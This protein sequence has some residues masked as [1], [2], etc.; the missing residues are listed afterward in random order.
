M[1]AGKQPA[2]KVNY[3][4]TAKRFK[5]EDKKNKKDKEK[6]E[7]GPGTYDILS[8]WAGKPLFGK[9][10]GEES[11]KDQKDVLK[12]ITKGPERSIYY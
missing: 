9:K 8:H 6:G 2:G 5:E 10:K 11:G 12:L 7:P 3:L 1:K 4:G